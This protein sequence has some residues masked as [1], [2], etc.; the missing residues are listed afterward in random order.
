MKTLL[1]KGKFFLLYFLF[2]ISFNRS[3]SQDIFYCDTSG[4]VEHNDTLITLTCNYYFNFLTKTRDSVMQIVGKAITKQP[5]KMKANMK[6]RSLNGPIRYYIGDT[7]LLMK[8]FMREGKADSLFVGYQILSDDTKKESYRSTFKNGFKE[9]EETEFNDN[10][11]LKY[12]RNYKYGLL[13]GLFRHLD[14]DGNTLN[15]GYY[16][17]GKK[18]DAWI[19]AD[20]ERRIA[21]YQ[22]YHNDK[23][24][25]YT[26]TSYYANGKLFISGS[27]DSKDR[28]QGIFEIYD[29]DGE[30]MSTESYRNGKLHG[31]LISYY[32]GKPIKKVK[33]KK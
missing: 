13:D 28:K 8:G 15:E 24:I 23:L 18:V 21:I 29:Q 11:T 27:Y 26:W 30:L 17:K 9:G 5:I 33:F 3:I 20:P 32:K 1:N 19:E 4:I 31:Y 25:G 6:N 12:L 14:E 22:N 10:G 7:V 2:F 16:K